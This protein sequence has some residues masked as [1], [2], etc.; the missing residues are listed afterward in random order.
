VI[1]RWRTCVRSGSG[2]DELPTMPV[3]TRHEH[4]VLAARHDILIAED[5]PYRAAV[6]QAVIAGMLLACRGASP[7]STGN[8]PHTTPTP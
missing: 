7:S 3:E 4:L 8:R 6:N 2:N 1:N 5:S